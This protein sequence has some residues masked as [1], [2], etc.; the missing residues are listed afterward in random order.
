MTIKAIETTYNGYRFRSRLEARWAV[1]FDTLGVKYQYELEGYELGNGVRY[2]PDFWLPQFE[3]F[4]EI[5]GEFPD[6]RDLEKIQRLVTEGDKKLILL[7]GEV[8]KDPN[9]YPPGGLLFTSFDKQY[10]SLLVFDWGIHTKTGALGFKLISGEREVFFAVGDESLKLKPLTEFDPEAPK[11]QNAFTIARQA[12][13][14][15]G[16]TPSSKF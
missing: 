16:E 12:R 2:L 14:E 8:G 6:A 3:V 7:V 5:K 11:L 10:V 13:F 15:H 4:A 9:G 1:F